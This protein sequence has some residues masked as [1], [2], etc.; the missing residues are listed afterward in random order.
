MQL[1]INL[2]KITKFVVWI[3]AVSTVGIRCQNDILR[4]GIQASPGQ[5]YVDQYWLPMLQAAAEGMN[6]TAS[7][8]AISTDTAGYQA[9]RES[10]LDYFYMG[11]ALFDCL[12]TQYDVAPVVSSIQNVNNIPT[13]DI[14]SA[15]VARADSNYRNITDV[16]GSRIALPQLA[17]LSSCQ[18]QWFELLVNGVSLFMDTEVVVIAGTPQEV[19]LAVDTGVVDI[20]FLTAGDLNKYTSPNFVPRSDFV[21]VNQMNVSFPAEVSTALYPGSLMA[22]LPHTTLEERTDLAQNLMGLTDTELNAN[23]SRWITFQSYAPVRNIQSQLQVLQPPPPREKHGSCLTSASNINDYVTCPP[24]YSK[25]DP[26][27]LRCLLNG[28][29]CP[30]SYLCLCNPCVKIKPPYKLIIGLVIPLFLIVVS[31]LYCIY[32][33]CSKSKF[34]NVIPY[35]SLNVDDEQRI[36]ESSKGRVLRGTYNGLSVAI[37]R[38]DMYHKRSAEKSPFDIQDEIENMSRMRRVTCMCLSIRE[39]AY[40]ESLRLYRAS[41]IQHKHILPLTGI[42]NGPTKKDLLK[43]CPY[44]KHGT[45]YDFIR[46]RTL[47]VDDNI[48]APIIR[49]VCEALSFLHDI[50]KFGADTRPHHLF[51]DD[52]YQIRLN[53]LEALPASKQTQSYKLSCAPE[54]LNGQVSPNS[55]SDVYAVGMLMYELFYRKTPYEGE[56]PSEIMASWRPPKLDISRDPNELEQLME[57]CC[58]NKAG[59]R[60]TL[61]T[62]F[63]IAKNHKQASLADA[64]FVESSRSKVLLRSALPIN[65]ALAL[66]NNKRVEPQIKTISLCLFTLVE[67]LA[68][69][70]VCRIYAMWD[71]I[72][73]PMGLYRLRTVD[74][75]YLVVGNLNVS[76]Q[77]HAVRVARFALKAIKQLDSLGHENSAGGSNPRKTTK[78]MLMAKGAIH[79]GEITANIL[80]YNDP[81]YVLTGTSMTILC[82]IAGSSELGHIQVSSVMHEQIKGSVKDLQALTYQRDGYISI[83]G[84]GRHTTYWLVSDDRTSLTQTMIREERLSLDCSNEEKLDI[85]KL[86]NSANENDSQQKKSLSEKISSYFQN[87]SLWNVFNQSKTSKNVGRV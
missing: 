45:V 3:L 74:N 31:I 65:V 47:I 6:K 30:S 9:V 43:I 53:R 54:L 86:P 78:N 61:S 69:S 80:G 72:F 42:S 11:A 12:Q 10:S 25:R 71:E 83:R 35:S 33:R 39:D 23:I 63:R 85:E 21:Y 62:L 36:G 60:P 14:G 19:I 41:K 38:S 87:K 79:H 49:D 44:M 24:G 84:Q 1:N 40:T 32:S 67:G 7:A 73:Q 75:S 57:A 8:V 18:A 48:I 27:K 26:S 20:G 16:K 64:L 5:A 70:L 13:S 46:N 56:L 34:E 58:T 29:R 17:Y 51:V 66:E 37:K 15:I 68:E 50:G 82:R 2:H 76:Q 52:S 55:S 77:D 22:A 81:R 59:D 4:F 28:R